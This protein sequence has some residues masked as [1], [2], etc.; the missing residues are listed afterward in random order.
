MNAASVNPLRD[1][2]YQAV[3]DLQN[4]LLRAGVFVYLIAAYELQ[5][6]STMT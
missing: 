4:F 1:S 5:L 2:S 3:F 6:L